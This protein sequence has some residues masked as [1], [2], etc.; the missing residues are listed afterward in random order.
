MLMSVP[1]VLDALAVMMDQTEAGRVALA[2][3]YHTPVDR[4]PPQFTP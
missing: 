2:I 1:A 4:T 3:G